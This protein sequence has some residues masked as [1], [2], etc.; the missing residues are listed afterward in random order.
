MH[1]KSYTY[2]FY[3]FGKGSR[4][5]FFFFLLLFLFASFY[6]SFSN[7]KISPKV[8]V[9]IKGEAIPVTGHGGP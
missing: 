4:K 2:I 6:F 7:S 8:N 5:C 9:T 3:T 1:E